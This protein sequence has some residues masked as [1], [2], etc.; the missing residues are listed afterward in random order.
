MTLFAEAMDVPLSGTAGSNN[1]EPGYVG[2]DA[3]GPVLCMENG[4]MTMRKRRWG[5]PSWKEGAKPITNIRNLDSSW[6]RGANG[7]Y[8]TGPEYR[9]LIPFIG[10]PNGMP[11]RNAMPGL[12][13]MRPTRI[14]LGSGGRGAASA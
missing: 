6:W 2:A 1:Y 8:I 9:C 12:P 13:S 10:L 4:M 11:I 3:D 5:F 7:E 14:S